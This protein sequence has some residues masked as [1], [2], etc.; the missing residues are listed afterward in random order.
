[1]VC[2]E[3]RGQGIAKQLLGAACDGLKAQGLR[4]VVAKPSKGATGTAENYPG[5]LAMYLAAGFNVV[6]EDG[7][8]NVIVR[9]E[10]K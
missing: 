4:T 2:P 7:K 6:C 1:M 9:K 3:Y 8:G 10:L 5:P